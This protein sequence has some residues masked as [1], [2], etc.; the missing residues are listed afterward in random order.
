M[1]S[2]ADPNMNAASRLDIRCI[3]VAHL[4]TQANLVKMSIKML[5][6]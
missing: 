4:E 5:K 3:T 6:L 2:I 1:A